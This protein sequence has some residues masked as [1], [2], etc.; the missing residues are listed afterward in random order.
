M[1]D[2][3]HKTPSYCYMPN[4]IY[5]IVLRAASALSGVAARYDR[6]FHSELNIAALE[7]I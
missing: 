2:F 7:P 1:V 3:N 6:R 4:I 5:K